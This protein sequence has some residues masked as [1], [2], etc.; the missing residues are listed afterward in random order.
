MVPILMRRPGRNLLVGLQ[1]TSMSIVS[2]PILLLAGPDRYD[3]IVP[4]VL[5]AVSMLVGGIATIIFLLVTRFVVVAGS[6]HELRIYG[7]SWHGR[8]RLVQRLT[9]DLRDV[10]MVLRRLEERE[11]RPSEVAH[12]RFVMKRRAGWWFLRRALPA[13]V[14]FHGSAGTLTQ[15]FNLWLVNPGTEERFAAWKASLPSPAGDPG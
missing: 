7:A 11:L 12:R 1:L 4:V 10:E 3:E 14:E 15:R 13:V 9:G 5:F 8:P 6:D 2:A